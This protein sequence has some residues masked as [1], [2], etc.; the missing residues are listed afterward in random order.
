MSI[1]ALFEG[2]SLMTNHRYP[3][4]A[5]GN[6]QEGVSLLEMAIVIVVLGIVMGGVTTAIFKS[7][8]FSG[9]FTREGVIDETGWRVTA[10]L[11]EEF[12]NIHPPSLLPLVITDSAYVEYREVIGFTAGVPDLGNTIIV[13]WEPDTEGGELFD[14]T[15]NNGDGRVDEGYITRLDTGDTAVV[16]AYPDWDGYAGGEKL[17]IAGNVIGFR[18]NNAPGGISYST[19]VGLID[20]EGNLL[21]ESFTEQIAFRNE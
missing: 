7:Q 3:T 12:Y 4:V 2:K 21:M 17:R 13:G 16:G 10:R 14:G 15:D 9:D 6:R 11:G 18:L 19:D 5:W 1:L 8:V 20:R